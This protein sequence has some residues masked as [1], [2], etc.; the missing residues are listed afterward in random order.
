MRS[1]VK[2]VLGREHM[3]SASAPF[4]G[5]MA[6]QSRWRWQHPCGGELKDKPERGSQ[7]GV[8]LTPEQLASKHDAAHHLTCRRNRRWS[9]A[10]RWHSANDCNERRC[11]RGWQ[12]SSPISTPTPPSTSH[13][14]SLHHTYLHTHTLFP[15]PTPLPPSRHPRLPSFSPAANK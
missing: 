15:T 6:R 3:L 2:S 11:A 12:S 13:F 10:P 5:V 1:S 14:H 9:R 4:R 7:F 8:C